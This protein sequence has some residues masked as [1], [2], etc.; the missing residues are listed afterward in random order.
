MVKSKRGAHKQR[1]DKK[2]NTASRKIHAEAASV[3]KIILSHP[4]IKKSASIPE[5]RPDGGFKIE[6][7]MQV[8]LPSRALERGVTQTGVRA[9]EP[10][11]F[12]F[13]PAYPYRAPCVLL[14]PDFNSCLPHINPVLN[15]DRQ[16]YIS[17]CVYD[18]SLNDLLHEEG[19]GLSEILNQL[20]DWLDKAAIDDLIDPKQ[21]WE[22]IRR[23]YT[24]GSVLYDVSRFEGRIQKEEGACVFL[25]RAFRKL[26]HK[27]QFNYAWVIDEK[28]LAVTPRLISDSCIFENT[29]FGRLYQLL[30]VLVWGSES[31]IVSRYLPDDVEN[32][33][34][35]YERAKNYGVF[36]ALS[37]TINN[38]SWAAKEASF[39][40]TTLPLFVI[41][42][43]R[44]PYHLIGNES[45]LEF[46]PYLVECKIVNLMGHL[47]AS[48][49]TISEDSCV[50]PLG[51][52][53]KITGKLLRR[54][55]GVKENMESG[56]IVHIGCG[57]VGSK[58][59]MSL[60][61][62]GHGPFTLIDKA[63]FSPHNSARHAL[64]P[65]SEIPGIPKAILLSEEIKRLGLEAEPIAEDIIDLCRGE[66]GGANPLRSDNR[67][68]VESTGS[69][70]VRDMLSSLPPGRLRGKLVHAILYGHG[71]VGI[72]AIEGLDRNPN[73]NDLVLKFYDECVDDPELSA[74]FSGKHSVSRQEVGQ[75]CGSQT[76]V[77]PDT[78]VSL[79][80]AGMA[81]RVMQIL[82][83]KDGR[84]R[85]G[86]LWIGKLAE[87]EMGVS[88]KLVAVGPTATLLFRGQHRWEVR[89]PERVQQRMLEE[90]NA[91]GTIETGGVLMGRL[92]LYNRCFNISRL[93]EAPPDS[94][95]A[96]NSFILGTE[97]LR[98]KVQEIHDRSGETLTYLG[99]WHSH[100]QGGEA[101]SLDKS[102]LAQLR[103]LPFG[104]PAVG[105]IVTPSGFRVIVD[106]GKLA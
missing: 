18:G 58:I 44:R 96:M 55:S 35:L 91:W 83:N 36:N 16:R 33:K 8:S 13:P 59:A 48:A 37:D 23:D 62:S 104:A 53:H 60:A 73:V 34:Q 90:M 20:S 88:W 21:G 24:S 49:L 86:E 25:C 50:I 6:F 95:R 1:R 11:T 52:R 51:H 93:V 99:T 75:G 47:P 15:E 30:T 39:N 10:I 80:S 89:I 4:C 41:L 97:G 100:P 85:E 92:S 64:V 105:L 94:V 26:W 98:C 56:S 32:L 3:H 70:A 101:S 7:N 103:G 17:P 81:Q 28:P 61:R 72:L 69:I 66:S 22:P 82:S 29:P 76:M 19:D 77:M 54:M 74:V 78:R 38:L 71:K 68:V 102:T 2:T 43:V 46:I 45:S 67:I 57:S 27:E 14:R 40:L 12:L 84:T 9:V 63:V 5:S 31:S 87:G 106:E 79:F 42:C 65:P